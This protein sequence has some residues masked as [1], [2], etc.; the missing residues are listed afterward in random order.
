[1]ITRRE[2]AI[3]TAYTGFA[4]GDF[5]DAQDYIQEILKRPVWTHELGTKRIWE[6]IREASRDDFCSLQIEGL[7]ENGHVV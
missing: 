3:I 2:A 1:M 6:E 7:D 5:G 4:L